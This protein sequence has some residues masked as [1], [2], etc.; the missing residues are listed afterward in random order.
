MRAGAVPW[1]AEAARRYVERGYWR[2]SCLG[3]TMW[4]D[5]DRYG[6]RIAIVDGPTRLSFVTL[7]GR[8]DALAE[9]LLAL[10]L[11]PGDNVVVQLP[12][13]WELV[14]TLFACARI[15]VAPVLALTQHRA[16][17]LRH[18]CDTVRAVALVVPAE[19]RGVDHQRLAL[20]V[21]GECARRPRVLV[22]ADHSDSGAIALSGLDVV[23]GDPKQRR[24]R[25]DRLAPDPG[26]VLLFLLSGGTT[27]LPKVIAR[28]HNDYEYNVRRSGEVCGFA[29]TTVYLAALPIAHN[30]ALGSPGI[31]AA[32]RCGGRAVLL[33]TPE[34]KHAFAVMAAEGAT[35]TA[36]VPAVARRWVD[37]ARE[38]AVRPSLAVVQI[39]GS[40]LP[41]GLAADVVSTFGCALQQVFGMA[42]GLLNFTRLDDPAAV[43]FGTQGR[44][45]CPDDEIRVVAGDGVDAPCG[46]PGELWTRGPYTPRGYFAAPDVNRHAFTSDGWYR[47]GDLVRRDPNGNLTVVGRVKDQINRAGEKIAAAEVEDLVRQVAA[48]ADVAAVPVPDRDVGERVCVC[49]VAGAQDLPTLPALRSAL[50]QLGV[51]PFKAPEYLVVVDALPRT[52]VG[53]T[54]KTRLAREVAERLRVTA[55]APPDQTDRCATVPSDALT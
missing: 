42:E 49:V 7:A 34:P 16:R 14:A 48:V 43:V 21:V 41:D 37:V 11:R 23:T 28:T 3:A 44:P 6:E 5:A 45:M 32:L 46:T 10:G 39:G 40:V 27:G 51:A 53:K 35:V 19:W 36:L 52:A 25:L 54:D 1:P 18:L 30:F 50:L 55:K 20:D 12:N 9:R 2:Q 15:G 17:E 38:S 8:A 26:D 33:P 31:L 4:R 29:D 47:T 13:R 22:V 24:A